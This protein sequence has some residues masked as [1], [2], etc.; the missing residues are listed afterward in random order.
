M[1]K[2]L[3]KLVMVGLLAGA[4]YG[5]FIYFAAPEQAFCARFVSVCE[6]EG[7]E[8][9][10][11]CIDVLGS[12]AEKDAGVVRTATNCAMESPTC[13]K[14]AGCLFGAGTSM[15]LAELQKLVPLVRQSPGVVGDFLDGIKKGAGD[16][17]K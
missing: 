11:I 4:A 10:D 2:L 3:F 5:A 15:G 1:K 12:I 6:L 9:M 14:A 16:L 7:P 17:L 8:P 13:S